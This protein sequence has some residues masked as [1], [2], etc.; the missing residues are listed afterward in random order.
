MVVSVSSQGFAVVRGRGRG[1]RTEQVD[2]AVAGL[3]ASRDEAW[4]RAAQLTVLVKELEERKRLLRNQVAVVP[5]RAYR[6]LGA[7]AQELLVAVE[8]EAAELL[9]VAEAAAHEMRADGEKTARSVED[10]ARVYAAGMRAEAERWA[11]RCRVAA[12]QAADHVRGEALRDAEE[13]RAQATAELEDAQQQAAMMLVE[14]GRKQAARSRA[15]ELEIA[16]AE[17]E[18]RAR[19]EELGAQGEAALAEAQR[20][21]GEAQ[22]AAWRVLVGAEERC[23]ELLARARAWEERITRETERLLEEHR[24][25]REELRSAL[26]HVRDH[27]SALTVGV[28]AGAV[29]G[30]PRGDG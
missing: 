3:E 6:G 19:I 15:A 21:Y 14:Q 7:R 25:R 20:A 23:E 30:Q 8:T 18:T 17:A 28:N 13:V 12:R 16:E 5:Q 29:R 26:T 27:L 22:E 9:D 1:Y 24:V 10:A 2:R 11:E 4:E